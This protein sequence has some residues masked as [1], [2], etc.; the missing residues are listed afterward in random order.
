MEVN[1]DSIYTQ[2]KYFSFDESQL[3]V[4]LGR[5]DWIDDKIDV[6]VLRDESSYWTGE[7]RFWIN[8]L[9]GLFGRRN[10]AAEEDWKVG[11]KFRLQTC[12]GNYMCI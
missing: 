5:T 8:D 2:G 7:V 1:I 9:G 4:M 12:S 3:D 11:D 6:E 10:I